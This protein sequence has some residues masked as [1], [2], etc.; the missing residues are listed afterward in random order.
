MLLVLL[1]IL[2]WFL[3]A[4]ILGMAVVM[5]T[6][7]LFMCFGAYRWSIRSA[8]AYL[9]GHG[10]G[11]FPENNQY[12]VGRDILTRIIWV[13]VYG[14]LSSIIG[15]VLLPNWPLKIGLLFAVCCFII[16]MIHIE[17]CFYIQIGRLESVDTHSRTA[18]FTDIGSNK[19]FTYHYDE[20]GE[21]LLKEKK[22][23]LVADY[24]MFAM[25]AAVDEYE[26]G[27]NE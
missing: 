6:Y 8:I 19:V 20:G 11:N 26:W 13:C 1:K 10:R 22:K 3:L 5:V 15:C 7:Y 24:G 14:V 27:V 9:S 17:L 21:K 12:I 25:F 2:G 4:F 23:Y 16:F 18:Y